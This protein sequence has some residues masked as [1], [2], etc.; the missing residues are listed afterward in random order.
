MWS[1]CIIRS[2]WRLVHI[3]AAL[4]RLCWRHQT[5]YEFDD[6][7]M[8]LM[9]LHE[10][11]SV[12]GRPKCRGLDGFYANRHQ[13]KQRSIGFISFDEPI[14]LSK[15]LNATFSFGPHIIGLINNYRIKR[16]FASSQNQYTKRNYFAREA[17]VFF[18]HTHWQCV[19]PHRTN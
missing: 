15:K 3:Y 10:L 11:F 1:I 6:D 8:S 13:V 18:W 16:I 12:Y 5:W 9:P 2:N 14:A 7:E 17:S 4:W 19:W